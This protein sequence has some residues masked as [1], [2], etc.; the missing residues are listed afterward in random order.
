LTEFTDKVI[1]QRIKLEQEEENKKIAWYEARNEY[2]KTAFKGGIVKTE[3]TDKRK[4]I[5]V[6]CSKCGEDV[7]FKD[8]ARHTCKS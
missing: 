4:A 5:R 2:I 3:Y 8:I 1:A 7:S 6:Y